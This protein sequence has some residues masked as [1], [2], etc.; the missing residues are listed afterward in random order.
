M[1]SNSKELMDIY[2]SL[3]SRF[4]PRHWWPV[5]T[6]K[7][8]KEFEIFLGAILTQ[9]TSWKQV[10]KALHKLDEKNLINPNRIALLPTKN[11]LP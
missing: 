7:G 11:S 3:H 5:T 2:N 10:E 1:E 4:G 9:Q 8:N 6:R